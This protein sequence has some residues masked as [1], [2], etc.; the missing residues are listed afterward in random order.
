MFR[1]KVLGVALAALLV[2]PALSTQ[3][4]AA[5]NVSTFQNEEAITTSF[6]SAEV[7]TNNEYAAIESAKATTGNLTPAMVDMGLDHAGA[8]PM[9]DGKR[10]SVFCI[11][12]VCSLILML[13]GFALVARRKSRS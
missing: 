10:F 6:R 13:G 2:I 4:Y 9:S 5:S 7:N 11:S 8:T 1:K 3:A 12:M